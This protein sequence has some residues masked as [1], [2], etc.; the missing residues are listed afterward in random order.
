MTLLDLSWEG[1]C[2]WLKIFATLHVSADDHESALS[3]D[4]EITNKF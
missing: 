2:E 4:F 3:I 1:A